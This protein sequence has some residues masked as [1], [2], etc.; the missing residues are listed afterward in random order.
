LVEQQQGNEDLG[1]AKLEAD[2]RNVSYA[3]I[4]KYCRPCYAFGQDPF[5]ATS[6]SGGDFW[7][8]K[9]DLIMVLLAGFFRNL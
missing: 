5:S 8:A 3:I 6:R 9:L 7:Y 4:G 2:R 1:C